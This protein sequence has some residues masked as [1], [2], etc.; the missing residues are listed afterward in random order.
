MNEERIDIIGQNGN[1][2]EHYDNTKDWEDGTLGE[3]E[4]HMVKSHVDFSKSETLKV[5]LASGCLERLS[6]R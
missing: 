4:E 6:K 5:V 3:S 2:G 1:D